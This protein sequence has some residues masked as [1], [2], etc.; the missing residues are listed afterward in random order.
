MQV[1]LH[2]H[3]RFTVRTCPLYLLL[4][5]DYTSK[6][7]PDLSTFREELQMNAT[8]SAIYEQGNLRLFK[9]LKLPEQSQVWVQVLSNNRDHKVLKNRYLA[10]LRRL[11]ASLE[12]N[13]SSNLVRELFP[14]LLQDNLRLLWRIAQPSQRKVCS[15]LVLAASNIDPDR[16]THQQIAAIHF[17]LDLLEQ[18]S[19]TD[20]DLD[21]CDERLTAVNLP[22]AFALDAETVQ[23]YL[24]EE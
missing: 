14:K 20:A 6:K 12:E 7:R 24:E 21:A 19:V 22:P 11:L 1:L 2:E 17:A 9:P 13:W 15:M 4:L 16:L 18:K 23:S 3:V 10:E 8:L 5:I